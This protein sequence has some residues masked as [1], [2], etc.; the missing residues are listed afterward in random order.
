MWACGSERLTRLLTSLLP[1]FLSFLCDLSL[2]QL[3]RNSKQSVV[4]FQWQLVFSS[5][6]RFLVLSFSSLSIHHEIRNTFSD[7]HSRH[8]GVGADA[9]G[10]N[11]S[12]RHPQS[13]DAVDFTVLIYHS[14]WVRVGAHLA[15]R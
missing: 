7:D 10:H 2:P 15:G 14:H 13:V 1:R 8:V 5:F 9:I 12:V 11:R 3:D 4:G 6:S